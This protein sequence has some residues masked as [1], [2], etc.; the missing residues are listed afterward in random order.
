LVARRAI[1]RDQMMISKTARRAVKGFQF[2][3]WVRKQK[4]DRLK[5]SWTVMSMVK[6]FYITSW[7]MI[8]YHCGIS[9]TVRREAEA[10]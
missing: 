5:I 1:V 2:A 3:K 7:A 8:R 9:K 10:C 4:W 6:K